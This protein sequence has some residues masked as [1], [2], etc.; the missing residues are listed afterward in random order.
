[1]KQD[2]GGGV[3]KERGGEEENG[4]AG[5]SAG[6]AAKSGGGRGGEVVS[7]AAGGSSAFVQRR[8]S[9]FP[10]L[11][12]LPPST[13]LAHVLQAASVLPQCLSPGRRP[14]RDL[15]RSIPG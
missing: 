9:C 8:M 6:K 1:M 13:F 3:G 4:E 5:G 7:L 11:P 15:T 14:S 10:S 12:R 2:G